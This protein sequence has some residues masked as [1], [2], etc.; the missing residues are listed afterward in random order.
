MAEAS[1]SYKCWSE[2]YVRVAVAATLIVVFCG[3]V[4]IFLLI[5]LTPEVSYVCNIIKHY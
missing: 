1:G 3:V 5:H 2:H 4:V